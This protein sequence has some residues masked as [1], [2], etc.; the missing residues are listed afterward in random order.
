[1]ARVRSVRGDNL[2]ARSDAGRAQSQMQGVGSRGAAQ[3]M[4]NTHVCG[5]LPFKGLDVGTENEAG[6]GQHRPDAAIDLHLQLAVLR[7][8]VDHENGVHC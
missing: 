8:E 2:I 1:M 5:R 4:F 7:L 6:V 3:G